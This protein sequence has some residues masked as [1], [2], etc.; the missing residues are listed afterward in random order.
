[1]RSPRV[2]IRT[3][4]S[5]YVIALNKLHALSLIFSKLRKMEYSGVVLM[6]PS[7][8]EDLHKDR[9]V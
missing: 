2:R 1:M 5:S 3:L 7:N 9:A 6:D 8:S 4:N